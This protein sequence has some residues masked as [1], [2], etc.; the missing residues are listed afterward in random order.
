MAGNGSEEG[1]APALQPGGG[2]PHGGGPVPALPAAAR[3]AG[4]GPGAGLH[5]PP[6]ADPLP[7]A[8]PVVQ[9]PFAGGQ[10]DALVQPP[11]VA[12]APGGG[13]GPGADLRRRG[14]GGPG[15]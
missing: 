2:L 3:G 12:A 15:R 8:G 4:G 13:A 6:R 14:G 10:R 11:G 1:P 5:P 9:A 7:A